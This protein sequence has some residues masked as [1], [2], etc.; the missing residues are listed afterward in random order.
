VLFDA[1]LLDWV[2]RVTES[3]SS[4]AVEGDL[5]RWLIE[6]H[7]RALATPLS[8]GHEAGYSNAAVAVVRPSGTVLQSTESDDLEVTREAAEVATPDS[9]GDGQLVTSALEALRLLGDSSCVVGMHPDQATEAVIDFAL[10][11]NTAFAVVPC[12][13]HPTEFPH[14]VRKDGAGL[15][16]QYD[17]FVL[18]LEEKDPRIN[19]AT[20]PISGRNTVLWFDPEP[21]GC[22]GDALGLA[23][24][25][26][27]KTTSQGCL[28]TQLV[29]AE[30]ERRR[31]QTC[32][33]HHTEESRIP[34]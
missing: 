7:A 22:E 6:A 32:K 12:C 19:R 4:G 16:R 33:A 24:P 21:P 20:L 23:V 9:E 2:A 17:D 11:H 10:A 14:R 13:V 26:A 18:Y 29:A 15:V 28:I 31:Q 30:V 27:A 3:G 1:H 5:Q 8:A 34:E 25:E